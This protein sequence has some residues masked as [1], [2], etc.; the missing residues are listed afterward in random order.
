MGLVDAIKVTMDV[1][2]S[3]VRAIITHDVLDSLCGVGDGPSESM[4]DVFAK[5]RKLVELTVI[6]QLLRTHEEPVVVQAR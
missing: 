4:L 5:H 3:R 1:H 2:G 6:D